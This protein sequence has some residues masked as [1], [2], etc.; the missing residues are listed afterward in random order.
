MRL[1]IILPFLWFFLVSA[2]PPKQENVKSPF[3][4][5]LNTDT[6]DTSVENGNWYLLPTRAPTRPL[7]SPQV[8]QILLAILPS[9]CRIKPHMGRAR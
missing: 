3:S 6:F 9:L 4:E 7:T 8:H 2:L 5:E 1:S